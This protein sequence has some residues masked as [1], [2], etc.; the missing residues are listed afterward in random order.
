MLLAYCVPIFYVGSR[1]ARPKSKIICEKISSRS[2]TR[3][4]YFVDIFGLGSHYTSVGNFDRSP[5]V[6][7]PVLSKAL[8]AFVDLRYCVYMLLPGA[9]VRD[10]GLH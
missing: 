6:C 4:G 3:K 2:Q 5:L 8:L 7:Y 10:E 9:R 1:V